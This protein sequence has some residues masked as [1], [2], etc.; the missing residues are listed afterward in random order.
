MTGDI[1]KHECHGL[2]SNSIKCPY[3]NFRTLKK[4]KD[5]QASSVESSTVAAFALPFLM[6]LGVSSTPGEIEDPLAVGVDDVASSAAKFVVWEASGSTERADVR[7]ESLKVFPVLEDPYCCA[8][9]Q[10]GTDNSIS[11]VDEVRPLFLSVGSSPG[12]TPPWLALLTVDRIDV[13]SGTL[14]VS[15]A[16]APEVGTD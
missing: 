5:D 15:F 8:A 14:A 9:P 11:S 16:K 1:Y 4:R 10:S 3:E 2:S 12:D 6:L 13:L 7:E